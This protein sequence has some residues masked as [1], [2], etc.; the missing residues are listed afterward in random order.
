MNQLK[1]SKRNNP[2]K[3][4]KAEKH[5]ER[6]QKEWER[7]QNFKKK[8]Q[9]LRKE[10]DQLFE[11]T[12]SEIRES[13]ERRLQSLTFLTGKL[14]SFVSKK[15]IPDYL[16]DELLGWIHQNIDIVEANPFVSSIDTRPIGEYLNEQIDLLQENEREKAEKKLLKQGVTPEML[17]EIKQQAEEMAQQHEE[18]EAEQEAEDAL[19]EDIFEDLFKEFEQQGGMDDLFE[20]KEEAE[21]FWEAFNNAQSQFKS[22]D[23]ELDKLLKATPINALFRK[24]ARALHPDLETDEHQKR[25]KHDQMTQLV[26]AREEKDI[27]TIINMY[28]NHVGEL[29]EGLFAGNFE[30]MTELL[31]HQNEKLREEFHEILEENP[32]KAWLY[33]NFSSKNEQEFKRRVRK[34]N[35]EN[36]EIADA[37][38]ALALDLTSIQRLRFHLD[39]RAAAQIRMME[40]EDQY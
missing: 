1:T 24:I 18:L 4:N 36:E 11:K 22:K 40:M 23:A 34:F 32:V 33:D 15:S 6:F 13:E 2:K 31:K 25:L 12:A 5:E 10:L 38:S 3:R 37:V 26:Q 17:E 20:S 28:I 9:N 39:G 21:A 30:K 8:N 14:I 27:P 29:P 19:N 7:V 35:K 16:R